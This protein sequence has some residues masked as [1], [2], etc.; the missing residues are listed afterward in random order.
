MAVMPHPPKMPGH[1]SDKVEHVVA[2]LVLAALGRW[3]YP[4]TRKRVLLLGL[5]GF[6]ALIEIVQAIPIL[7]RDS[8]PSDWIA[9]VA[10]SLAVFVLIS[11]WAHGKRSDEQTPPREQ[12]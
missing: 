5:S 10:A 6:G 9:D 11:L 7:H 1:P 3:A 8:D 2:F 12:Q 4:E